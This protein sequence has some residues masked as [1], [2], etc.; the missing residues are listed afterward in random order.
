MNTPVFPNRKSL[1]LA[2]AKSF[3][4][5]G[6]DLLIQAAS[7]SICYGSMPQQQMFGSMKHEMKPG[8]APIEVQL[9][10]AGS[11]HIHHTIETPAV[12]HLTQAGVPLTLTIPQLEPLLDSFLKA[13]TKVKTDFAGDPDDKTKYIRM[14]EITI[15]CVSTIW[16]LIESTSITQTL[17]TITQFV[18]GCGLTSSCVELMKYLFHVLQTLKWY[19]T[20]EQ[21][22]K[23]DPLPKE[24]DNVFWSLVKIIRSMFSWQTEKEMDLSNHRLKRFL[25]HMSFLKKTKDFFSYVF[26]MFK[27][28]F[29]YLYEWK[30][31]VPWAPSE[32][33]QLAREINDF[34]M[35]VLKMTK[36][37]STLREE[38][39][40]DISKFYEVQ[41][42]L[43]IGE[44]LAEQITA[45]ETFKHNVTHFNAAV[46]ALNTL[47]VQLKQDKRVS[48]GRVPPFATWFVGK[49]GVGK[50]MLFALIPAFHA[51]IEEV[52]FNA[53]WIWTRTLGEKFWSNYRNQRFA[54]FDDITQVPDPDK[55]QEYIFEFINA[56][57]DMPYAIQMPDVDAKGTTFFTSEDVIVTSNDDVIPQS[58]AL[59]IAKRE[60]VCRRI[61]LFV[62]VRV[63]GQAAT[64]QA[65]ID[66]GKPIDFGRYEFL[67]GDPFNTLEP[68]K[69]STPIDF[70]DLMGIYFTRKMKKRGGAT[71][72]I[73]TLINHPEILIP[74]KRDFLT[75]WGGRLAEVQ[76]EID[77][78]EQQRKEKLDQEIKN[79]DPPDTPLT[80]KRR[81]EHE[82]VAENLA[83]EMRKGE[84]LT[85]MQQCNETNCPH[86][87]RRKDVPELTDEEYLQLDSYLKRSGT[88]NTFYR[89]N[90]RKTF[91][92]VI[93]EIQKTTVLAR[94]ETLAYLIQ[95]QKMQKMRTIFHYI[96][97][98]LVIASGVVG[99]IHILSKT[100][101]A[102]QQSLGHYMK[103]RNLPS[104]AAPTK[105]Q[106]KVVPINQSLE[107]Q[108]QMSEQY[109]SLTENVL[110]PNT[111][112]ISTTSERGKTR[113][114][115]CVF[116]GGHMFICPAHFF[117][118]AY[119]NA[120]VEFQT[121]KGNFV[122][123]RSQLKLSQIVKQDLCFGV[124]EQPQFPVF[125]TIIH[126]FATEQDLTMELGQNLMLVTRTP[127][128]TI[129]CMMMTNAKREEIMVVR[130]IAGEI[131]TCELV[132]GGKIPTSAGDCG[133]VYIALNDQ[134]VHKFVA[135]H[136]S[137]NGTMGWGTMLTQEVIKLGFQDALSTQQSFEVH[138]M[139][140]DRATAKTVLPANIEDNIEII[141]VIDPPYHIP[142]KNPIVPSPLTGIFIE[143][144]EFPTILHK[145]TKT[146]GTVIDPAVQMF[147]KLNRPNK[148]TADPA[149]LKAFSKALT[150]KLP[151]EFEYRLLT[152]HEILNGVAGRKELK[153]VVITA[154]AGYPFNVQHLG[155]G[156]TPFIYRGE[157]GFLHMT[158]EFEEYYDH[159][160]WRLEHDYDKLKDEPESVAFCYFLKQERVNPAKI[161]EYREP[162]EQELQEVLELYGEIPKDA[163][164]R[165]PLLEARG[166]AA[167]HLCIFLKARELEGALIINRTTGQ[168]DD[169]CKVGI[170]PHSY[171]W[172]RLYQQACKYGPERIRFGDCKKY[173]ASVKRELSDNTRRAYNNKYKQ[174]K[175]HYQKRHG[176]LRKRLHDL[177]HCGLVILREILFRTK[178]GNQS[179]Q[180]KT[181]VENCDT[182]WLGIGYC[183]HQHCKENNIPI[184]VEEIAEILWLADFG[185]DDFWSLPEF[186]DSFHSNEFARLF[187]EIFDMDYMS[188]DKTTPLKDFY[189][190]LEVTFL[191]RSFDP[192][193]YPTWVLA[194]TQLSVIDD[195]LNWCDPSKVGVQKAMESNAETAC[196]EYWHHKAEIYEQRRSALN[197][198]M[199]QLGWKTFNKTWDDIW[200]ER[201]NGAT[202]NQLRQ[203]AVPDI[204]I[205]QSKEEEDPD[206][207]LRKIHIE[208]AKEGI[209]KLPAAFTGTDEEIKQVCQN[210][211]ESVTKQIDKAPQVLNT[212]QILKAGLATFYLHSQLYPK[213]NLPDPAF[214]KEV[215]K[216][217]KFMKK[218]F[219]EDFGS[220]TVVYRW[221]LSQHNSKAVYDQYCTNKAEMDKIFKDCWKSPTKLQLI[222]LTLQ[223]QGFHM[224]LMQNIPK[225]Q[226]NEESSEEDTETI[227]CGPSLPEQCGYQSPTDSDMEEWIEYQHKEREDQ[228]ARDS[229][230]PDGDPS[231]IESMKQA[232]ALDDYIEE[233]KIERDTEVFKR[234]KE[235][236][237]RQE[238]IDNQCYTQPPSLPWWPNTIMNYADQS[239]IVLNSAIKTKN[240]K[241]SEK[242]KFTDTEAAWLKS[243]SMSFDCKNDMQEQSSA[244]MQSIE[245]KRVQGRVELE[246]TYVSEAGKWLAQLPT[247][248]SKEEAT[249]VGQLASPPPPQPT[250][251]TN[252]EENQ[253]VTSPSATQATI[254]GTFG[255]NTGHEQPGMTQ[256]QPVLVP[257]RGSD[258]YPDQ[259]MRI[260]LSR[261]YEIDNITWSYND[262]TGTYLWSGDFPDLL[263]AIPNISEKLD[264]F[265]FLRTAIRVTFRINGVVLHFGMLQFTYCPH[266]NSSSNVHRYFQTMYTASNLGAHILSP[267]T[268]TTLDMVIPYVSPSRW[269]NLKDLTT[270][271]GFTGIIACHVL[272]PLTLEAASSTPELNI[273]VY[274]H[275]ETPDVA[276][277][278]LRLDVLRE[279]NI[280]RKYKEYIKQKLQEKGKMMTQDEEEDYDFLNIPKQQMSEQDAKTEK[281]TQS[282]K[283]SRAAKEKS[284]S[285]LK[286]IT[287]EAAEIASFL[288]EMK[289]LLMDKPLDLAPVQKVL[290][291]PQSGLALG[292]GLDQVEP[293][294]LHP[295]NKVAYDPS[296]YG[297]AL[298]YNLFQNY[299]RRPS[300]IWTGQ[301]V[302]SNAKGFRLLNLPITPTYVHK[303]T[304]ME[305]DNY[306]LSKMP[307]K[308]KTKAT[309][310]HMDVTN[311]AHMQEYFEFWRGSMM[312]ALKIAASKFTS[313]RI[314]LKWLPDPTYNSAIANENFGDM[315]FHQ[316]DVTGDTQYFVTIPW[317]RERTW[318]VAP[319]MADLELGNITT[320][321][322]INGQLV[323]EVSNPLTISDS[324]KSPIVYFALYW[325]GAPDFD[326]ARPVQPL[327]TDDSLTGIRAKQTKRVEP[328][329]RKVFNKDIPTQQSADI[330]VTKSTDMLLLFTSSVF[331][332]MVPA[333]MEAEKHVTM[334]ETVE[335]WTQLLKRYTVAKKEDFT[336]AS[337]YSSTFEPFGDNIGD[338]NDWPLQRALRAFHF[339]RGPFRVKALVRYPSTTVEIIARNHFIND[340]QYVFDDY[341][342]VGQTWT[343]SSIR[344]WIEFQIPFYYQY[345]MVCNANFAKE[346]ALYPAAKIGLN[347]F[348]SSTTAFTCSLV[349][350]VSVGDEFSL[351]WPA[352]PVP[353]KKTLVPKTQVN[354]N[355]KTP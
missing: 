269:Q 207:T 282:S 312:I 275:L 186:L 195:S 309:V 162:T 223:L 166:V 305:G 328:K 290:V 75:R 277:L 340:T 349:W 323:I 73:T 327:Y 131:T 288:S 337:G 8:S 355:N 353:L 243:G 141:G 217:Q 90:E 209:E 231:V 279:K 77:L 102:A 251:T 104:K 84:I 182:L 196:Y 190:I 280:I 155:K 348:N 51:A 121:T 235:K 61:D 224:D 192:E 103:W 25:T 228:E 118:I 250:D 272:A 54:L 351:G 47:Y 324:A 321:D 150:N 93:E 354:D 31:K 239:M 139:P 202:T 57:G 32:H 206:E 258:P 329:Q 58:K 256:T 109:L 341:G 214:Q 261:E 220:K 128:N 44:S 22:G 95:I 205:Q 117:T 200:D 255:D 94:E 80:D 175:K 176:L 310:L 332:P 24:T 264:R 296:M 246:P 148:C 241:H 226:M 346:H 35:K 326:V 188:A 119:K 154:S 137:G 60:A 122:V 318:E 6:I 134:W 16:L 89:E 293:L 33:Q 69:D 216:V 234:E 70:V 107:A 315:I 289:G 187:K 238:L 197:E 100:K 203:Y 127:K 63:K 96:I 335:S 193:Y 308:S 62:Q 199:R 301:W 23:E 12:D 156:K 319:P 140:Y 40:L 165:E 27:E 210:A 230:F 79:S 273:S 232:Q 352:S 11:A 249:S 116:V 208:V 262:A 244:R 114:M 295:E 111:C 252:K 302:G 229:M 339:K 124:V 345:D 34:T 237:V 129:I 83:K 130:T 233:Q 297:Q 242:C 87:K 347:N 169:H 138:I 268:N 59:G 314:T 126:H 304:T 108:Q 110:A 4:F 136:D 99:L 168:E 26:T 248:Q 320:W 213:T 135:M 152:K 294:S 55:L 167:A 19:F 21:Q 211:L 334:G 146:D 266:Y 92:E 42:L 123:P 18:T 306:G 185:D 52:P 153:P 274:A 143:P 158:P 194:P 283:Y 247:Q 322:G 333:T 5:T 179:G 38:A 164:I 46:S 236:E 81:A 177:I 72:A 286:P 278:G 74:V 45:F 343:L 82:A 56:V 113:Q 36:Y 120:D 265:Q 10:Q 112:T 330:A 65:I 181:T 29:E 48:A 311:I 14:V 263:L 189:H 331:P 151:D 267:N 338:N 78:I 350:Y 13:I 287:T 245:A 149:V 101:D 212:F 215:E 105:T 147:R 163:K 317:L 313:G 260:V 17:A 30:Y 204:P 97:D 307:E 160:S 142:T 170:N 253:I 225:Q 222:L 240:H 125:K 257:A 144:Q 270:E 171:D 292:D 259:G 285:I 291:T 7:Q 300:L 254:T 50:T 15:C 39:S 218:A 173:D 3:P 344:P 299:K 1:T 159:W 298:D 85:P 157:D 174:N 41:N 28:A 2:S 67:I 53:N 172:T 76:Q 145:M 20:P 342:M 71:S 180:L 183:I 191:C 91:S 281:R 198:R 184:T 132:V 66:Y 43:M 161:W 49:P 325:A 9:T 271:P 316:I 219:N 68:F 284:Q 276:G 336:G 88:I 227:V 133:G 201:L 98:A 106:P 221:M 115:N 86:F 303:T 37:Y 64:D 178:F